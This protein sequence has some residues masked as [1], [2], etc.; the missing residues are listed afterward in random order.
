[1][2]FEIGNNLAVKHGHASLPKGR[3][4][5]Y[6]LWN[7]IKT[8]CQNPKHISYRYYGGRGILV[9]SRWSESFIDFLTDVSQEIGEKPT[10]QH[11]FDRISTEGNYEPG[12]IRWATRLQQAEN[13]RRPVNIL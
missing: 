10:P 1:M 13:R 5:W 12:N 8:R 3:T 2:A 9:C 11:T 4:Y 6:R 7:A